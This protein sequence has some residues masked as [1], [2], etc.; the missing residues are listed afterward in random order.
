MPLINGRIHHSRAIVDAMIGIPNVRRRLL[1]KHS[2]P[3]PAPVPVRLLVDTGAT[4]SGFHPSVFRQLDLTPYEKSAIWTPS[5]T[6][7]S[8]DYFDHY[9]VSLSLVADGRPW[10]FPDISVFESECWTETEALGGVLGMD[11]LQQCRLEVHGPDQTF[12][13]LF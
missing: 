7:E 2:F 10:P 3:I 12:R 13:L 1:T 9:I 8:P 6:P 4:L 11:I 5:T